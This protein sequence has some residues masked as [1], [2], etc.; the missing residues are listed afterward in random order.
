M[1][2]T[3]ATQTAKVAVTLLAFILLCF[4]VGN[5]D[6]ST[7]RGNRADQFSLLHFKQG[8]NDPYGALSTWKISTHFC[9]WKGVNCSSTRPWRVTALNLTSQS[10]SG[11]ISSSLGN[12][13]FLKTL[14]LSTNKFF[15]PLPLLG[16]LK[17]L[18]TLYLNA[19]NLLGI[20]PDELTNCS[21]LSELDLSANHL[22]GTIP[23]KLGSL[24]NLTI[25]NLAGNNLTGTIP[26][27]LGNITALEKIYL[28]T[29]Q[30]QGNIPDKLWQ[31]PN[32]AIL[33]L[34]QNRLSGEIPLNLSNPSLEA[35]SLG[36][37]ML[38]KEL[39]QNISDMLPNIVVLFLDYNM[40]QGKIPASLGNALK[41]SD[42]GLS[43]NNFTG[44]IPSSF[45]NLPELSYLNL[46]NNSLEALV[47]GQGW[48]FLHALKNCSLLTQLSVSQNQLQGNIPS[49]IGNLSSNLQQLVLSANKLTGHVP[50]SIGNLQGLIKLS[51]DLNN[52]TGTIEGWVGKLTNLQEL[53]LEVNNF[54][55]SIPSSIGELTNLS[56]LLLAHNAL[57]G[58]IPSSLGNISGLQQ[59]DLSY[60][61]LEGGIPLEFSNLKQL[62]NITL[63][64]NKLNGEIPDTLSQCKHLANIQ[65]DNNR[66]IGTIPITFG[67][68]TSLDILNLSHNSLSGTI[69]TTLS[70]LPVLSKLDLSYNRL[71]GKIP[72]T[73]IF[74]NPTV[75]SVQGNTGLCGGVMDLR[76]PPCQVVTQRRKTEYYLIRVLIPIFGFMSLILVIYFLLLEKMK[77]REKYISSDSLGEKFL[78]VSY[79]DLA[80][81]T[82]N[83][84]DSNLVGKGSYGT[85]YR[86]KLKEYKLEV[87]VKVFDLEMRGAERSF[88]SECEA[89]RSIQHRNL[90]PIITACSTVDSTG[91]VFK[92]LVYEYM[93]NGNLDTWI[94]DKESGKAPRRPGLSQTI[95]ICVNI[96]DALDYLHHECGRTTIHCDLK[97]SNILLADDMN[98][99][100]GDFGISRFYIDT[101]STSTGSTSTIG[102]KGTIGYIAP[103]N[104][105]LLLN[106][107][108]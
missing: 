48:E 49:S 31:L 55:E 59:L 85:V 84:S 32:M 39:P 99:L 12:L 72:M 62:T 14:D 42:I 61:N 90:L 24:S 27:T 69:P 16:N 34:G 108:F 92:A 35:L 106:F 96:A 67:D 45:G 41:L 60:N 88:M 26:S 93:P 17:Q 47:N 36:Y 2:L 22:L 44:Q 15:G 87:A 94:H 89:L 82:R 102:L 18:E 51:L 28:D 23:Q 11:Q 79:N 29:N 97:P 37:N 98:A 95:S 80:Q 4:V 20:I 56:T 65:M 21:S 68:L 71:Q 3:C 1:G 8:I 77:P 57:E 43:N 5:V 10:L 83:F 103:G 100:L 74:A 33:S 30:F 66:L 73:G 54:S 63:S 46:E 70:D 107:Q 105:W 6:C 64:G 13:S 38:G 50:P 58:H 81:A 91:N 9:R 104:I 78:K 7:F 76:M 101:R 53:N 25:L 52:L 40:F 86:G 75:V 19:N